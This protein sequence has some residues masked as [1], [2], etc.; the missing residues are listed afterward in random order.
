MP[1]TRRPSPI[2]STPPPASVPS[3]ERRFERWRNTIGLFLGPAAALLLLLLPMDG[4]ST[5]AHRLAAVI[6]WVIVWWI[7]EP[8]PI[9]VTALVGAALAVLFGIA[10]AKTVLAPFADPTIYLFLGSFVIARG[11][12][13]HGLDRRFAY[14][15]MA[16]RWV[17]DSAART[18][19]MFGAIAAFASMWISNTATT[20][21]MFPIALGIVHTMAD[22]I[23]RESGR[24]VD[25]L[26]LRF[27]T[28]MMLMAAY[29]SSAGGIATPV[30]TPPNLIGLAMIDKLLGTRIPFF[31]WMLFAFPILAVMYGVLFLLML[32]LHRPEI[33]R[34]E[35]SRDVVSAELSK[36][37]R[38]TA[39]ERNVLIAFSV[40]VVLWI[41]PGILSLA[42][43]A[44]S[45]VVKTYGSR[46]PEAV[47]ALIGASLL[48]LLPVDWKKREFTLTWKQATEINWGT[49]LLFG[50]G[51]TLGD[52]MFQTKLAEAIG[53]GLLRMSGAESVW[54]VTFAAI[55]IS[56]LVS[57]TTSNTASATM[58]VPVVISLAQ[59]ADLN[60]L[61][62]A[63][64]ATL[65]ASWGFMLPVSTPP[66]AIVYG[67]GMIPITKM[68]RAG[69]L[70]DLLGGILLWCGLRVLLPLLG[71]A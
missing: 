30:G 43:G 9:P 44:Q 57:E 59:A 25:P 2:P 5:E 46:V 53:H 32:R 22:R 31:Q 10:P 40:A 1:R 14:R 4:L 63:I 26:R 38:M 49:L 37:G 34:V 36:L 18:L 41:L 56:I 51:I 15:L 21:M 50:G 71:L 68:V 29:A 12:S 47:A 33:G 39:G 42:A 62:P 70:F 60:P 61:P 11:M 64:G 55:W 65:G 8:I 48:F 45:S 3:A 58:V 27:G 28:G 67:S 69:L 20:A 7:T 24:P 54:G 52:L 23:S 6:G 13:A 66:N 35:G 16:V 19:F 17:G